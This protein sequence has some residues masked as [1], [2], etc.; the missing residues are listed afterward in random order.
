MPKRKKTHH[1]K[2]S[3]HKRGGRVGA[4][5]IKT[6]GDIVQL[7]T[8]AVLGGIAKRLVT[9]LANKAVTSAGVTISNKAMN[10]G[11]FVVGGGVFYLMDQPFVRGLGLGI[12]TAAVYDLTSGLTL[13]GLGAAPL[14]PFLPKPNI[15][16]AT[17]T[18]NVAGANVYQFPRPAGVGR[19]RMYGGTHMR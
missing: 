16:G 8:G 10:V 17:N 13:G 6:Q 11:A 19:N 15:N 2:H 12:S 14:V 1:K 7:A 5:N 9:T 4:L 3:G 18:P